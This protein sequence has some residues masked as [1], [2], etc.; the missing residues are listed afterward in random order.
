MVNAEIIRDKLFLVSTKY[1]G[2][3]YYFKVYFLE[4]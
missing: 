1:C 4:V 3:Y 2:Y